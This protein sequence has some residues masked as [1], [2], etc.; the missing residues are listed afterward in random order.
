MDRKT[1][2]VLDEAARI[3][4]RRAPKPRRRFVFSDALILRMWLWAVA[5]NQPLCWACDRAHYFSLLRPRRLPSVSQF[6]KR[7]ASER[8]ATLR[9]EFHTLLAAQGHDHA[10]SFFDG[11]ALLVGEYSTDPDAADGIANGRFRKGYKLH[12]RA[13]DS[14][15]IPEYTTLPLNVGEPNTARTLLERLPEGSLVLA[16]AN[17]D[18]AILYGAVREHGGRLLTR[19]KGQ[20]SR[21]P[22]KLRLMEPARLEAI[23]A[24]RRNRR[25]CEDVL[26]RRDG[27]ERV[28]AHLT[29]SGWGLGPLPAWVRTI[30]RVRLWVDAKIAIYHARLIARAIPA[31]A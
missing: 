20:P 14:G 27:V 29:S 15:F 24:W 21:S 22:E 8:F 4:A 3:V 31:A 1:W 23:D 5:H 6:C 17:Y 18:S 26:H 7:L 10:L 13:A 19:L 2:I 16:D 30:P 28:F 9:A 25:L 11:K 12:V